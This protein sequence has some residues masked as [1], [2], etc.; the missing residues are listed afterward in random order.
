MGE[1]YANI[2]SIVQRSR[3]AI[4]LVDVLLSNTLD[5]ETR[6]RLQFIAARALWLAGSLAQLLDRLD[7]AL[8]EPEVS[9]VLRTRLRAYRALASTRV[10]T[11]GTAE[12]AA[13]GV[14]ADARRLADPSAEQVALHAL[15]EIARN[16]QDHAAA[17]TYFRTL[18]RTAG[19]NYLSNEVAALRLL[20]RFTEADTV[21]TAASRTMDADQAASVPALIEARMWQDFMLGRMDEARAEALTLARLGRDLDVSIFELETTMVLSLTAVLRGDLAEARRRLRVA[22]H[23][24]R[25]DMVVRMPRLR[26]VGSLLAGLDGDP[27]RAVQIVKPVM[28]LASASNSYW[29]RLPEWM[30]VHAGLALAAGDHDFAR[31]TVVRATAAADGNPGVASL[32]GIALQVRGLVEDDDELLAAAVARL[33]RSPRPMLRA[34][35]L[36]DH[37]RALLQRGRRD[38]AVKVLL[39]AHTLYVDLRASMP[40]DAVEKQLSMAGSPVNRSRTAERATSGWSSLTPAERRVTSLISDGHTNRTAARELDISTN[41]LATHLRSVF[42]KLDVRSRV[43]LANAWHAH[44]AHHDDH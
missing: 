15:G 37:G 6:A 31:E 10:G 22:E 7:V 18:R 4:D 34:S 5:A 40:A 19:S 14:L 17:L 12:L 42:A 11:A 26:L 29:P 1:E 23:D 33:E 25:A 39:R 13:R 28:D 20:D 24:D 9:D 35:A 30:R 16:R 43:Q 44:T 36:A 21:V 32:A 27:R 41:T 3:D 38:D 2:L 8:S